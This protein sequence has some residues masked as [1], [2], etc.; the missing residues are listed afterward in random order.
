MDS[1]GGQPL[2]VLRQ[3]RRGGV[4]CRLQ[5]QRVWQVQR[6]RE[7]PVCRHRGSRARRARAEWC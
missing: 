6:F 7:G 5:G 4:R 1:G 2:G 3:D